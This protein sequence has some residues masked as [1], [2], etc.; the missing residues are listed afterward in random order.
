MVNNY[1]GYNLDIYN[2]NNL[3]N[4]EWKGEISFW[5]LI[6]M[7]TIFWGQS[8]RIWNDVQLCIHVAFDYIINNRLFESTYQVRFSYNQ[9][10]VWKFWL[11]QYEDIMFLY[12]DLFSMFSGVGKN[13]WTLL[14]QMDDVYNQLVNQA[15]NWLL[16]VYS[17]SFQHPINYNALA[18]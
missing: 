8:G 13:T 4:G 18:Y 12:R 15:H 14:V 6:P 2:S 1:D 10:C 7:N 11:I 17:S 5:E 9:N 16:L 3:V